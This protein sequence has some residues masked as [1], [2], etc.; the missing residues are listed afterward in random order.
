MHY[1]IQLLLSVLNIMI[2]NLIQFTFADS[3]ITCII[4]LYQ[5]LAVSIMEV[6][7]DN[8]FTRMINNLIWLTFADNTKTYIVISSSCC[9]YYGSNLW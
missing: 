1:Y 2:G 3:T 9:Q 7:H 4:M 6:I 5:A 8:S